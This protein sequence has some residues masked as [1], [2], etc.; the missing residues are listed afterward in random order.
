MHSLRRALLAV[1][2]LM[3]LSGVGIRSGIDYRN[4]EGCVGRRPARRCG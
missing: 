2:W 4:R 3:I 1:S